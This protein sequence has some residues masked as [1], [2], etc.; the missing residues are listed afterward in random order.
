VHCPEQCRSA[1]GAA[2]LQPH[3]RGDVA[4]R[5]WG[6]CLTSASACWRKDVATRVWGRSL[7]HLEPKAAPEFP[8]AGP[9]CCVSDMSPSN[10]SRQEL[11]CS[12]REAAGVLL[13]VDGIGVYRAVGDLADGGSGIFEAAERSGRSTEINTVMTATSTGRSARVDPLS[14]DP[15]FR[16]AGRERRA[17]PLPLAAFPEKG[18]RLVVPVACSATGCWH[19][20]RK[21]KTLLLLQGFAGKLSGI[22]PV[23]GLARSRVRD[24][25]HNEGRAWQAGVH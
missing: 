2:S 1:C 7:A 9:S 11:P 12:G 18:V 24:V 8:V 13:G 17:D 10:R 19:I 21:M 15:A 4:T 20:F 25:F 16:G 5:V 3:V 14:A 22:C 6:R 23:N